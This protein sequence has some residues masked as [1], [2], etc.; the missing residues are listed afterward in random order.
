MGVVG[1]NGLSCGLVGEKRDR[2][3]QKGKVRAIGE[4]ETIV[5]FEFFCYNIAQQ[6]RM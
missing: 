4:G 6:Y 2:P 5:Y 3:L 1:K